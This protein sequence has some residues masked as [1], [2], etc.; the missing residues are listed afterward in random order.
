M[1]TTKYTVEKAAYLLGV[2]VEELRSLIA[3]N[4]V[5]TV[6]E[7]GESYVSKDEIARLYNMFVDKPALPAAEPGGESTQGVEILEGVAEAVEV[8]PVTEPSGPARDRFKVEDRELLARFEEMKQIRERIENL[9]NKMRRMGVR[10]Q[11]LQTIG[12][13]EHAR[14]WERASAVYPQLWRDGQYQIED[15]PEG[16]FLQRMP[17]PPAEDF[18]E[19]F[20]KMVVEGIQKGHLPQGFLG[21]VAPGNNNNPGGSESEG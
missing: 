3:Q 2:K 15:T 18:K 10:L 16:I 13:G 19:R 11:R 21:I 14:F 4:L 20:Q 9:H 1:A 8:E 5:D 17:T 7:A 6:E 12:A